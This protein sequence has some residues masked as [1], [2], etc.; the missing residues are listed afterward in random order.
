MIEATECVVIGSGAQ[1][2][3][4][5]YHLARGGKQVALVDKHALGSQTSPRAAGLTSQARGT[6]LM[7]TLAKRAVRKIE[8]FERETG[9]PLVFYQPGA[10]KIARTP[11]H[12]EQ[13][14]DRA[15]AEPAARDRARGDLAVRGPRDEPVPGDRRHPRGQLLADRSLSGAVPD[16][17][18]LCQGGGAPGRAAAAAHAGERDRAA[19][20][21]GRRG[22]DRARHDRLRDRGRCRRRLAARGGRARRGERADGA[23]PPPAADHRADR[24]RRSAAADHPHHRRQ[25]LCPAGRGRA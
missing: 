4:V 7:T 3:S 11:D 5:A 16:P 24:G 8:A 9:E 2:A 1:G 13:L 19:R 21:C 17:Q 22:R 25:R 23:D 15:R 18:R 10:L 6:D 14:A 20:R 12:V